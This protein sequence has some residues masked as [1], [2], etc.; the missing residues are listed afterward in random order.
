MV[1]CKAY[2]IEQASLHMG[3]L[4]PAVPEKVKNKL[5]EEIQGVKQIWAIFV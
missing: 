1:Y 3:E 4:I 2:P 5:K